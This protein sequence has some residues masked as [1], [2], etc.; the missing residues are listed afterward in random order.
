[1]P[2]IVN[3]CEETTY[4]REDWDREEA[5]TFTDTVSLTFDELV[6]HLKGMDSVSC[7]PATGAT[8]E[9]LES[10]EEHYMDCAETRRSIH[11]SR[12]NAPRYAKYWRLAMKA[13]GH[14]R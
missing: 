2:I 4:N 8:Y 14:V 3:I 13:A 5:D 12:N 6:R 10:C 11:F 7:W 1:M 9:W